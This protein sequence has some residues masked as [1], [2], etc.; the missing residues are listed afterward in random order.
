MKAI[1][2]DIHGN[3]EALQAV[4]ADI[5]QQPV[6]DIYCLG[7]VVGYGPNP[8]ECV[9]LVMRCRVVLLGNHDQAVFSMPETFHPAAAQ[10]IRWT[11]QQLEAAQGDPAVWQ[12]RRQFLAERPLRHQDGNCLFVHGSPRNPVE[13][14]VFP[15]DVHNPPK[16]EALFA[17]VE[18]YCF[19]G[20]THIPGIITEDLRFFSPEQVECRFQW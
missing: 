6:D 2:S 14:Y 9:D 11:R 17:L 3:L 16:M 12:R 15:E 20:H 1:L 18:R 4:L 19:H 8:W 13:E 5:Q 10:A 7:D